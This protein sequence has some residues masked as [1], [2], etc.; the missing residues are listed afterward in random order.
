[1]EIHNLFKYKAVKTSSLVNLDISIFI[2]YNFILF[3]FRKE[4]KMN[5]SRLLLKTSKLTSYLLVN[6]NR[7]IK[8][9]KKLYFN[10]KYKGK[11]RI[12]HKGIVHLNGHKYWL[13][14]LLL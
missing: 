13:F 14:C 11:S 6:M 5:I 10:K 9:I 4:V 3:K 7:F 1:M 2:F 8:I 12:N